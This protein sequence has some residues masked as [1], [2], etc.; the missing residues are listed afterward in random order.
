M[1]LPFED[2][3]ISVKIRQMSNRILVSN[4]IDYVYVQ[5]NNQTFGGIH[6]SNEKL[7]RFRA[8]RNLDVLSEVDISNDIRLQQLKMSE[9]RYLNGFYTIR[10]LILSYQVLFMFFFFSQQFFRN[11]RFYF[12]LK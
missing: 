11:L 6:K 12:F 3:F 5:H 8:Q 2:L 7:R 4:V 9:Q 1:K 10:D